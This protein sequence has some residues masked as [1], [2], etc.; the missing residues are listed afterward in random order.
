MVQAD[1]LFLQEPLLAWPNL[2]NAIYAYTHQKLNY[3]MTLAR[4]E[5]VELNLVI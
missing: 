1:L 3:I 2:C 4:N 5:T